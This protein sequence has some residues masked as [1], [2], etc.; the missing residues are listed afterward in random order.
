LAALLA[1]TSALAGVWTQVD[2]GRFVVGSGVYTMGAPLL[3]RDLGW[4]D[5]ASAIPGVAAILAAGTVLAMARVTSG[6]L[7]FG[8]PAERMR[9]AIGCIVLLTCFGIGMNYAYRWIFIVWPAIWLLRRSTDA[10][11]APLQRRVALGACALIGICLW[12]D[13]LFCLYVNVMPTVTERDLW[14]MQYVLRL[15]TQPLTWLLM[16]LLAGWLIE[17]GG[18]TV[19]EWWLAAARPA[20]GGSR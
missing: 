11:L 16:F 6:L 3:L 20:G 13:G 14:H 10:A 5:A 18:S 8:K 12:T 4:E 9:A 15:W 7:V 1:V 19:R 2:R 17:A